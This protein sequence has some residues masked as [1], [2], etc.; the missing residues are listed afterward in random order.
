MAKKRFY[1]IKLKTDFFNQET[2]D[3]LLTQ[4]NGCQYIVLYQ[5]LCLQTANNNGEMTSKVGELI[6]PYDVKKIVRD[7]KYFDFDTV[8]MA[9]MLF[10]QLGLIY[11]EDDKILR[12]SNFEEMIGSEVSSAKRVREYRERQNA[13]LCNKNVTQEIDIDIRDK[14]IDIDINKNINI[15]NIYPQKDDDLF[16]KFWQ[17]YPKKL[18]K[19]NAKKSFDKINPDEQLTAL[20]ISQ[21]NRFKDTSDWKKED[22]KFIPYP[23]TWLNGKRWE[24]EFETDT[25]KEERIDREILEGTYGT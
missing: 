18:D 20:I 4:E 19:K 22:G 15:N 3:F 11:E 2:I 12:I 8:S 10:K 17:V 13:L 9:L 23:S 6:V 14:S 24:D 25:E 1:W 7:T 21:V 16:E 5:M